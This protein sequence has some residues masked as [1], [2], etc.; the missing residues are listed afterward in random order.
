MQGVALPG[1]PDPVHEESQEYAR[2]EPHK[3]APGKGLRPPVGRHPADAQHE[4]LDQPGR[5]ERE[6]EQPGHVREG[7]GEPH[8]RQGPAG[9][10]VGQ[11]GQDQHGHA[12]EGHEQELGRLQLV[13]VPDPAH[14]I[15]VVA[16]VD[17]S[18]GV[19][20][21][22]IV[23]ADGRIPDIDRVHDGRQHADHEGDGHE[24]EQP[25]L[26]LP[27]VGHH[28]VGL[29]DGADPEPPPVPG[30]GRP[31]AEGGQALGVDVP[32]PHGQYG[33]M[34]GV[35]RQVHEGQA[36]LGDDPRRAQVQHEKEKQEDGHHLPGQP[37]AHQPGHQVDHA[38]RQSEHGDAI[39][40]QFRGRLPAAAQCLPEHVGD[41]LA[42]R[43]QVPEYED[44]EPAEELGLY[45]GVRPHRTAG[46]LQPDTVEQAAFQHAEER[47]EPQAEGDLEGR[48]EGEAQGV[49]VDADPD[50][51]DALRQGQRTGVERTDGDGRHRVPERRDVPDHQRQ[52]RA[53]SHLEH[54]VVHETGKDPVRPFV[55]PD[56]VDG[57]AHEGEGQPLVGH[58][59]PAHDGGHAGAHEEEHDEER[60]PPEERSQPGPPDDAAGPLGNPLVEPDQ[61]IAMVA[62]EQPVRQVIEEGDGPLVLWPGE[63][64]R[65]SDDP[66]EVRDQDLARHEGGD[67]HHHEDQ[68]QF[69]PVQYPGRPP[70]PQRRVDD[71]QEE[72]EGDQ[73]R[74]GQVG[75]R[76]AGGLQDKGTEGHPDVDQD[77][78]GQPQD[79]GAAGNAG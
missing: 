48:E 56:Q 2:G 42:G 52:G 15:V 27:Q 46:I 65:R 63:I 38:A 55:V 11:A 18:E 40:H 31:Q 60:H 76:H 26:V 13:S 75:H 9:K 39:G 30:V 41:L 69:A 70:H 19:A 4:H 17:P 68:G 50:G 53:E 73:D 6:H 20:R 45:H 59:R 7:H 34:V 74:D 10:P 25:P 8:R 21:A 47:E 12:A 51:V 57:H 14:D 36:C 28:L 78:E 77:G 29:G 72:E 62:H 43:P 79:D 37:R 16:F 22:E 3:H 24:G 66:H 32:G 67:E 64:V 58:P 23:R 49:D 33:E 71:E 35:D 44:D 1:E 54:A 5:E 61:G